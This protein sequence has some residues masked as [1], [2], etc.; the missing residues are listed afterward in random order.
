MG[1]EIT[2]KCDN[3]TACAKPD[4]ETADGE[5][6]CGYIASGDKG[7][8]MTGNDTGMCVDKKYCPP[9]A[10]DGTG[11][12]VD[13]FGTQTKLWCGSARTALAMGAAVVSAYLA[14]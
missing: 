3:K 13:Y 14:M 5:V 10:L 11:A 12:D 8:N 9:G 1:N 7:V 4:G 6:I 2:K